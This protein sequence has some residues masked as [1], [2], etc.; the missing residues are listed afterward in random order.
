MKVARETIREQE[1]DQVEGEGLGM[2]IEGW[3]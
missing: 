3:I 1:G 2:V